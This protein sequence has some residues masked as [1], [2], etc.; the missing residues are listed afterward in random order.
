LENVLHHPLLATAW[1]AKKKASLVARFAM[2]M[3]VDEPGE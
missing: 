1:T 3:M 2:V